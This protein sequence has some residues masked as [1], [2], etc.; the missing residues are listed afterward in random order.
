MRIITLSINALTYTRDIKI[1]SCHFFDLIPDSYIPI[2][3]ANPKEY[4]IKKNNEVLLVSNE[5]L[6]TG[7]YQ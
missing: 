4:L 6:E 1:K 3:E 7:N 2:L 5:S